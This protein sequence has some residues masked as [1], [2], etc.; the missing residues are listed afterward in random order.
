MTVDPKLRVE[1]PDFNGHAIVVDGI[2][3]RRGVTPEIGDD[4]G[5]VSVGVGYACYLLEFVPL[6]LATEAQCPMCNGRATVG[7]GMRW[8]PD[9]PILRFTPEGMSDE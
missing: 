7:H 6:H 3:S 2:E 9:L 4:G 1:R 8:T 5:F